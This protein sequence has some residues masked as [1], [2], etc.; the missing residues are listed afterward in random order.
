MSKFCKA[1]FPCLV[2][3]DVLAGLAPACEVCAPNVAQMRSYGWEPVA[4]TDMFRCATLHH[5]QLQYLDEKIAS[6]IAA[7]N[8]LQSVLERYCKPRPGDVIGDLEL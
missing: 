4:G 6:R 1:K 8:E 3:I 2:S 5:Q 7:W